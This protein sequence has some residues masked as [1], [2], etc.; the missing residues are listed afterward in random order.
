MFYFYF[1][2]AR[3]C[4]LPFL[5]SLFKTRLNHNSYH[6]NIRFTF[7]C[8]TEINTNILQVKVFQSPKLLCHI[9]RDRTVQQ[10]KGNNH[11]TLKDTRDILCLVEQ[12][13]YKPVIMAM[14]ESLQWSLELVWNISLKSNNMITDCFETVHTNPTKAL[15]VRRLATVFLVLDCI[16]WNQHF[17]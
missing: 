6:G 10:N 5:N 2:F 16:F 4:I 8:L 17:S 15:Q 9:P 11:T 7:T 13:S 12:K 1:T 3:Y 14:L